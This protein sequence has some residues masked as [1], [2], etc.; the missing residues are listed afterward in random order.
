[1]HPY[2]HMHVHIHMYMCSTRLYM[3]T[4][5]QQHGC[6]E[7]VEKRTKGPV[8]HS[9][10]T[11]QGVL[12]LLGRSKTCNLRLLMAAALTCREAAGSVG[13]LTARQHILCLGLC[14]I[15]TRDRC[16]S[17]LLQQEVCQV[18]QVCSSKCGDCMMIAGCRYRQRMP[19]TAAS[20]GMQE[21]IWRAAGTLQVQVLPEAGAAVHLHHM[22]ECSAACT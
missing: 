21:C 6:V 19:E 1:M 7:I 4:S 2:M 12:L 11:F 8:K 22:W 17:R 14:D 3:Q 13:A 10:P 5:L 16:Y 18:Q 20:R 15:L 9:N